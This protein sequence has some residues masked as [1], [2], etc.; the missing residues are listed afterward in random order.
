MSRRL[1]H[2]CFLALL[3]LLPVAASA[4]SSD[5]ISRELRD[6]FVEVPEPV[7]ALIGVTVVDGTGAP[8]RPGQAVLIRDGRIAEIAPAAQYDPPGDARVI[9]LPGHTVIPGIVGLHD[10]T[11][12]TTSARRVQL[13]SSAPLMYL[14]SGV[15]TIRTTGSY[16]PYSELNLRH[17][18]REGR[19]VGPRMYVTGP[20]ITG[21]TTSYMTGVPDVEA[22]RRIVGYWAE[23]GVDWMKAYTTIGPEELRAAIDEAHRRGI[24]MTGHLCSVS[25]TEAVEMGIDNL[26][27]GLFTNSDYADGREPGDCPSNLSESILE[28]DPDGAEAQATFRAM[29]DNDVPMTSTLAV[30]ELI[31]PNRPPLEQR[32]LDMLAPEV[33]EEYMATRN[34]IAANAAQSQWPEIFSRAQAYEKAFVDAGGLL[35]A[36]VDPTGIGGALPGFGDQRNFELLIEAGFSPVEALKIMTLNGATI[37]GAAD[38]YGSLEPGKRAD[39][40]VIDGDP[41]ARPAEI[42][43]VVTVFRDGV[44]Y[45]PAAM[46]DAV[47]GSVGIR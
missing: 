8:P 39:L 41:I 9:S 11:F 22:A 4:Q 45:D 24:R 19:A 29:I 35:G 32:V 6:R 14:A 46:L 23:E 26:E 16:H 37:L 25:F 1:A 13:S 36:G 43:N 17:A 44:G 15:T 42:R 30:Y 31:V 18:I 5:Q 33:R 2:A 21:P 28:L 40:V 12:Y 20:Y 7:V 27:H 3:A 38:E 10:H 34:Q 47:R